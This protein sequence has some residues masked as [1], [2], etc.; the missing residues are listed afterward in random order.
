MRAFLY[1]AS[2]LDISDTRFG[3]YPLMPEEL[4]MDAAQLLRRWKNWSLKATKN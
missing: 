4:T 3:C 1:T 2:V